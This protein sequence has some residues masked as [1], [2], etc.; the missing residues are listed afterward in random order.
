VKDVKIP[1]NLNGFN[2][3]ESAIHA[4]TDDAGKQTRLL[5][6]SPMPLTKNDILNIY[7]AAYKGV[8]PYNSS[9]IIV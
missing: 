6:R 8:I 4:L 9:E 7:K 1:Q 3:P 5:A 2:I